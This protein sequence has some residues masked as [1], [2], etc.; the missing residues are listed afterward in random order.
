[1][2]NNFYTLLQLFLRQVVIF[3]LQWIFYVT[4]SFNAKMFVFTYTLM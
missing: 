2:C 1:M 3:N 4:L